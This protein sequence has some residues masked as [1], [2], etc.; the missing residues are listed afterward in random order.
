MS[1]EVGV[2]PERVNE[3][4]AALENLRDVLAANV[5]VI[6]GTMESYWDSGTGQ[7][8]NLM[9]LKQAQARSVEDAANMRARSVLAQAWMD[10]PANIDLVAGGV[11]YLPW[12][13]Q[14]LD[15][16][17]VTADAQEL[18]AAEQ[19]GN[20]TQIQAVE[21]DIED[22]LDEGT[23]GLPFL[24]AFYNQAGTRV[25]ALAGSLY[26]HGGTI[27][28][29]LSAA[30]QRLI[31]T[32][33]TGLAYVVKN[34]TGETA[35]SAQ[36]M[37]AL[38]NAPDMWSVAM[39]V[40]YGPVAGAYGSS[41]RGPEFLQAV[42][43]ATVTISPHVIVA[44]GDPEVPALRAAWAWASKRHILLASS[45]GDVEFSRWV[46]IATLSPYRYLF[47][48]GQL[49]QEFASMMPDS[50]IGGTFNEGGKILLS[51]GGLGAAVFLADPRSLLGAKPADVEKLIPEGFSGPNPL[52]TG[53]PGWRY[54]D[55]KTGKM[56]AYEEGSPDGTDLGQPDSLLHQGPYYRISEN[57]YIYRIA[58]PGNPT[59]NDPDA[60]TISITAPDGSKTYLNERLPTDDPGDGDGDSGDL[61]EGGDG[62]ADAGAVDG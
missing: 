55:L 30:D 26:S 4:A 57:G 10:N 1:D 18:A 15:S 60:V 22:H 34:G 13:G 20:V 11:A 16:Q 7:P 33:A 36:A 54:N 39:L 29:P 40:K 32:F 17:D 38:T 35:L 44:A 21:Q 12:E 43:N 27:E 37:N 59:L 19:S 5:P 53:Q 52:K 48:G 28:Q 3:L 58:A 8:V 62:G 41:G 14:A 56:V 42:S 45:P 46:E 9:R 25:A 23:A 47:A 6:V 61:G 24:S 49:H 31:R 51:T 2:D 50:R